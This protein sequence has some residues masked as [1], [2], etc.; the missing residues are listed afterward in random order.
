MITNSL[1]SSIL[2]ALFSLLRFVFISTSQKTCPRCGS[3]EVPYPLSTNPNCGDPSYSLYC[4][5]STQKLYLNA[6]NGSSYLVLRIQ[7][8]SQ[9]FVIQPSPWIKGTC[10][11]QD[12][13]K[14]EGLW[15]NQS[16][17][18]NITDSNTIFLFNCSPRLLVSPLNCTSASLCHGYLDDKLARVDPQ[19]ELGCATG[20]GPCCTFTAGGLPS[21][22][23]IRLHSSGCR[24]FRSMLRLDPLKPASQWEEGLEIQWAP[25]N[26]PICQTQSDCAQASTCSISGSFR[27]CQC[28]NGYYWDPALANCSVRSDHHHSSQ[29][30]TKVVAFSTGLGSLTLVTMLM[31]IIVRFRHIKLSEQSKISKEREEMLKASNRGR[32]YRIFRWKEVKKATNGFSKENLLGIGGFGEVYKGKLEDGTLVAVKLAK[33][34]D[35]RSTQQILNEVGILSLVNHKNLVRLLGCCVEANKQPLMMYEYIA[36]GTLNQHLHNSRWDWRHRLK[37]AHQT[38][39]ALTYLHSSCNIPIYHRDVKSTNILLDEELNAK[40]SDFGLSRLAQPGLS[41][42]STC[43]QGTLGYLDP[44]YYRNYQLTDKSDVYSFGV[45][46]LE[47]LTSKKVIDFGRDPDDVNL[48]VYVMKKVKDGRVI[49]VFDERLFGCDGMLRSA[50]M[51]CEL[52]IDCLKEKK[53]Q[54]PS[55]KEVVEMLQCIIDIASN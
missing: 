31:L 40:V 37:V 6:L 51:L 46:L 9:R 3:M 25:P 32:C 13:P 11:T 38:A 18:F 28:N 55:M 26:E 39:E 10:I 33:V 16:L 24:A 8:L 17:P 49:D 36:N 14:S 22:Y 1:T 27:R 54:R 15:L 23:K 45:V 19:D 30:S 48:A 52:A 29:F 21:S 7:P 44:E 2:A 50:D 12:M 34:G 42:V 5:S 43:A 47:L 41:H 4:D 20:P 53:E 35:L